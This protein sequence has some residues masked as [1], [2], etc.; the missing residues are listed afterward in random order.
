MILN[1]YLDAD[2][3]THRLHTSAG[4]S[5]T[6]LAETSLPADGIVPLGSL[7]AAALA[8]ALHEVEQTLNAA[9]R[10][11][12]TADAEEPA[13]G[14]DEEPAAQQAATV[15]LSAGHR[16][17]TQ[18]LIVSGTHGGI[19]C[20]RALDWTP[21]GEGFTFEAATDSQSIGQ[22]AGAAG[23]VQLSIGADQDWCATLV[24]TGDRSRRGLRLSRDPLGTPPFFHLQGEATV[25]AQVDAEHLEQLVDQV[26]PDEEVTIAFVPGRIL[27]R[28]SQGML[29]A[30]PCETAG[31]PQPVACPASAVR[32]GLAALPEGTRA[33]YLELFDSA[34]Q[35]ALRIADHDAEAR[36]AVLPSGWSYR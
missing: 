20:S 35:T 10:P 36:C 17:G 21:V 31:V 23:T 6:V 25:H 16:A 7:D 13:T 11:D 12:G 19:A 1:W 8:R 32:S 5:E 26:D 27:V 18:L 2:G 34:G 33:V 14:T 30:I 24:L 15:R 29:G 28:S 22:L 4:W 9:Q 3:A